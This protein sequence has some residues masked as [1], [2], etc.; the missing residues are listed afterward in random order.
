VPVRWSQDAAL[1][2]HVAEAEGDIE[3]LREAWPSCSGDGNA[4]ACDGEHGNAAACDGER[5][6]RA[7]ATTWA[8]GC[9]A[10]WEQDRAGTISAGSKL[11]C[12]CC[13]CCC[14]GGGGG[15]YCSSFSASNMLA[16][17]FLAVICAAEKIHPL[18]PLRFETS[19]PPNL[20]L[21]TQ[22]ER[23]T[24]NSKRR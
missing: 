23:Q 6:E 22:S 10:L 21:V 17:F 8:A 7:D 1:G 11:I 12:C 24:A 20:P 15:S 9:R 2:L 18:P 14:G 5:S 16:S 3:L 4:A 13:C 19:L